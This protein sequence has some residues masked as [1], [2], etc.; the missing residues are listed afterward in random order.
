MVESSDFA[1]YGSDEPPA[2][3]LVQTNPIP[4]SGKEEASALQERSYGE[5]YSS[6]TLEKQSQ[7]LRADCR[8]GAGQPASAVGGVVGLRISDW[9]RT[10]AGTL[11]LRPA[12]DE[13]C[14]TNPMGPGVLSLRLAGLAEDVAEW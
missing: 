9:G 2:G 14:E 1:L 11:A 5:L 8:N 13:T 7:F 10:F 4:G 6:R 3:L 12:Q